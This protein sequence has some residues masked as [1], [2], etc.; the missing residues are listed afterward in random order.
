MRE[1][2]QTMSLVPCS[3]NLST[4]TERPS[5][6]I[7]PSIRADSRTRLHTELSYQYVCAHVIRNT[8]RQ[9][10]TRRLERY[11]W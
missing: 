7:V 2:R 8:T 1:Q 6:E 9:L 10:Q 5:A 3:F 4:L 11:K